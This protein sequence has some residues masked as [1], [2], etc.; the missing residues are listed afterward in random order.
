M[1]YL[2]SHLSN[3]KIYI[4]KKAVFMQKMLKTGFFAQK[5]P[6]TKLFSKKGA[7]LRCYFGISQLDIDEYCVSKYL[8]MSVLLDLRVRFGCDGGAMGA[9][10]SY[11]VWI[12]S[13]FSRPEVRWRKK[14][15]VNFL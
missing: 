7:M 9:N 1:K 13:H 6:F 10:D 2:S 12:S 14:L 4:N 5:D 11:S 8:N 3:Q 15:N